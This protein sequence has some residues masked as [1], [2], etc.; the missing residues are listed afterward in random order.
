MVRRSS[1]PALLRML[2]VQLL[3]IYSASITG[4]A[5]ADNDWPAWGHGASRTLASS[6]KNPPTQWDLETKSHIKWRAALGS[7][8]RGNP[9]VCDGVVYVGTNND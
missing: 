3:L 4:C 6:E 8:S 2:A 5:T 7:R 1:V 9:V